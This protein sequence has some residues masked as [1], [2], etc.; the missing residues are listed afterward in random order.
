MFKKLTQ[1][2]QYAAFALPLHI[3][4]AYAQDNIIDIKP[5]DTTGFLALG[6]LTIPRIISGA[7]SLLLTV[8]AL[9]FFFILI[10]G[11]VRWIMSSGDEKAVATAR[12]QITNAL[13]G[14][15]I[16]FAAYAIMSLMGTLF[17][18]QLLNGFT[19]TAF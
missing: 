17:G 6:T 15:A 19:L 1:K 8:V 5:K 12:A 16:V 13:I 3:P 2:I 7:I 10:F 4:Y 14:L 9:V 18:I 11:G